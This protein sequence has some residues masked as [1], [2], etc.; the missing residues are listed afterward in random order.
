[1]TSALERLAE[2][3]GVADTYRDWRDQPRE[4]S[5]ESRAAILAALGVDA[6]DEQAAQRALDQHETM[7]WTRMAPP[8]IVIRIGEPLV[9]P[10]AVPDDLN[11]QAL[12]WRLVHEDGAER[13]GVAQLASLSV[14]ETGQADARAFSRLALELPAPSEGYHTATITLDSGLSADVRIIVAPQR[15]F[16]PPAIAAGKRMWG[17]AVQL[18]AL[19]SR[20]NWGMGDF[21]DLRELVELAAPLGCD[22][23]GVNPLHALMPADPTQISPYSPSSRLFLNVLYICVEEVADFAECRPAQ[24]RVAE[25][26]FQALLRELRAT[27][28]VDYVRVAGAKFEI[29]QM[30]YESFRR[31]HLEPGSARAAAFRN[32][33][34]AQG[35]PLRLHALY[36]ALD[37]HWRLQG[38]QYWGWPSWPE[39][40]RD[41]TSLAVNRFARERAHSVDYFLYLQW[42]ADTQLCETQRAALE[43]GMQIG[44]YGDVAVGASPAGSE[45][46][47]NRYLYV[48][49]ASIGAP[50]DALAL[51]GQDWGVPPQDPQELRNQQYRPFTTLIGNNMRAVE[52]LR[53]DHAMALYRLWWVPRGKQSKDGAYLHYP[54][55]DLISILALESH[56]RRC[57]VI[58]EDLG[59]VPQQMTHAM[60]RHGLYHYK[61][62]L[63][64]QTADGQFKP[65]SAYVSRALAVVTTHDL[66]T[67]RGWWEEHDL[68]LRDELDL[69]PTADYKAHAHEMRQRER[70]ELLN[71]LVAAGLWRWAPHEPTPPYSAALSRAVHAFLGL[72]NANIALVQIEDL[73]GMVDPV[74]VPGTHEEHANWRRKVESETSEIL[75]RQD[76]RDILGAFNLARTGVNPNA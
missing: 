3:H 74:N 76:V 18:Y 56:R 6:S 75:A 16:E 19:R 38:P 69:Y 42:L 29:L 43:L 68:H 32:Y 7:R 36:D 35:D 25:P 14:I 27:R 47:S 51:K 37:A 60:E 28:H 65:P 70:R 63:F 72:S 53:L 62:L 57:I 58:G 67:L 24:H 55:D 5:L 71:A 40:Y 23:V 45:T 50:P 9:A 54:L 12:S 15:C 34:E 11:A 61:V 1:M 33:V 66:P 20:R 8:V 2:L 48:Q 39:E 49:G 44:L 31:N 13:A 17:L 4:V 46:W 59:T 10:L 21:R 52:A 26:H 41:P 22:L 30:L 73:I 64:E